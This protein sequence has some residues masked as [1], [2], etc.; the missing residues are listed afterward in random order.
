MQIDVQLQQTREIVNTQYTTGMHNGM[1]VC[2]GAYSYTCTE[3]LDWTMTWLPCALV[4]TNTEMCPFAGVSTEERL[5]TPEADCLTLFS[6]ITV[7][8]KLH[9]RV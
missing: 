3:L 7:D 1:V 8:L 9:E 4:A 2:I 6:A 5:A